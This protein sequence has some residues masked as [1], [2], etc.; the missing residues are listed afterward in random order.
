MISYQELVVAGNGTGKKFIPTP[1]GVA[2][3]SIPNWVALADPNYISASGVK[4]RTQRD[5][6]FTIVQGGINLGAFPN[7]EKSF[8]PTDAVISRLL[9]PVDFPKDEWSVFFVVKP[10]E[11]IIEPLNQ[12][13]ITANNDMTADI[14][15]YA[16]SIRLLRDGTGIG[17]YRTGALADQNRRL[18]YKST[19][20]LGVS[21]LFIATFSKDL[22]LSIYRNG[23]KV[24]ENT[25]DKNPIND[26]FGLGSWSLLRGC[27]GDVGMIGVLGL[28]LNKAANTG[29]RKQIEEYLQSRYIG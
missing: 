5:S 6:N 10:V 4:N 22:G 2:M 15:K 24:A 26:Q 8:N 23:A 20:M 16:P 27:R 17:I 18:A 21:S 14:K 3:A 12:A 9:S 25:S 29:Y 13:I 28:D 7:G 19:D 1:E 11:K